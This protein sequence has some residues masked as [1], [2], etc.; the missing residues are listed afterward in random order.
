[1][2]RIIATEMVEQKLVF[3]V[4]DVT[5]VTNC[6]PP[7]EVIPVAHITAGVL[8]HENPGEI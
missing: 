2:A 4:N 6:Q 3:V 1:M 5:T 8:L 7:F